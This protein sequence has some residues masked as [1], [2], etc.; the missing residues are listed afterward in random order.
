MRLTEK[1]PA[2]VR[3]AVEASAVWA[4]KGNRD[5][6][7][8]SFYPTS[9]DSVSP[10]RLTSLHGKQCAGWSFDPETAQGWEVMSLRESWHR[11][12]PGLDPKMYGEVRFYRTPPRPVL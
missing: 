3:R 2:L 10:R 5:A 4:A 9:S 8:K 12:R 7:P 11:S 6:I 1:R